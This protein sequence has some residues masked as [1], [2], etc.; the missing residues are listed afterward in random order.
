MQLQTTIEWN[1]LCL[2]SIPKG[3]KLLW[4]STSLG[5]TIESSYYKGLE[6]WFDWWAEKP[7]S[8]TRILK[9]NGKCLG[10]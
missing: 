9:E 4:Y 7:K 3:S 2:T 1:K 6:E 8:P 5:R 10:N